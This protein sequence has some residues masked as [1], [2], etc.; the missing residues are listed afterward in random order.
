MSSRRAVRSLVAA[1]TATLALALSTATSPA[2]A[3]I[4]RDPQPWESVATGHRGA[5]AAR[6]VPISG[7]SDT[8]AWTRGVPLVTSA[9]SALGPATGAQRTS[10]DLTWSIRAS[11]FSRGSTSQL[12]SSVSGQV[13]DA[14]TGRVLWARNPATARVPASNQKVVTAFVALAS[15]GVSARLTTSVLQ[16]PTNPALVH[17]RG[18]GDPALS[19]AQLRSMARSVASRVTSQGM[20]AVSVVVDDSLFP[21]PTNA[22]GWKPEW[23]PGTVAPVRALVVD[24]ANVSDTSM[25]AGQVFATELKAAGVTAT[26]VARGVTPADASAIASVTSPT[27]GQLVQTMLNASHNDYAEALHRLS[28]LR[29]G[30]PATWEGARTNS[31]QVLAAAGV[32]R[33]G[34]VVND[35][36]GLS[37]TGR[38]TALTAVDLIAT[39]RATPALNSVVFAGSGMPTSGVSGTLAGRYDTAPTM[40]ARGDIRAKTGTLA[41]VVALSGVSTGVDGRERLFS[42]LVNGVTSTNAARDDVDA[43]AATSTGCY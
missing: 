7:D 30:L 3:G 22:P 19:S 13:V 1:S 8:G 36:S 40:C 18:A 17:L 34:M 25:H 24:Q 11:L 23:V 38:M 16:A 5:L 27:V 33:A 10:A 28:A 20:S 6:P 42:V 35:G 12:G 31:A 41:D 32:D 15:M 26:S 29:R 39:I 9:G 43:L 21:A 37:R 4:T 2:S 14:A